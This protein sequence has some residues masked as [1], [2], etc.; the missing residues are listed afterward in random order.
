VA[1]APTLARHAQ[2]A[3][4]AAFLDSYFT[5][6]NHRDYREYSSL[7]ERRRRLTAGQFQRGYRSTHDSGA[8]LVSLS[9]Q[10][11]GLAATVTFQSHQAPVASPDHARCNNWRITLY[12]QRIGA[13]YLV[14][15]P[16]PGYHAV[17]RDCH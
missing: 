8:A 5:A 11:Q 9:N 12:L 2:A 4:I 6:V 3:Q 13:V 1:I 16:P 17:Y 15:P 7:F 10:N 14:A